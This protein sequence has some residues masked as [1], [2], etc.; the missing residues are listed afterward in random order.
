MTRQ[1]TSAPLP[2][3][4]QPQAA[5]PD[6]HHIAI[7]QWR[8][9]IL[10]EKRD[11]PAG[12]PLLLECHDRL[13]PCGAL[14][15]V[16]LAQVKHGPLHDPPAGHPAVLDN[17]PITVLLA[18]LAAKLVAQ[19][20]GASLPK[21]QAV[22]QGAWS[23]P[24]PVS[25]GSRQRRPPYSWLDRHPAVARLAKP[26]SS[27]ESRAN[28]KLRLIGRLGC[29]GCLLGLGTATAAEAPAAQTPIGPI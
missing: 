20:H 19:K 3:P 25:A 14:A 15:V 9:A 28:G 18:V 4:A 22:S 6:V 10:G 16:D 2:G 11:L 21:P 8:R 17:A 7:Q 29:F 26:R 12:L 5:E 23:A 24:Q 1:P 13:T 27:C